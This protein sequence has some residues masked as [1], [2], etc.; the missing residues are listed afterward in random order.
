MAAVG[1]VVPFLSV[2]RGFFIDFIYIINYKLDESEKY[3]SS[4]WFQKIRKT[5]CF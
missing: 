3:S 4:A 1:M 2:T 5:D